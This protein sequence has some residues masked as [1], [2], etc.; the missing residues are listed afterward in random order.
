M[1]I[2]HSKHIM[3][4]AYRAALVPSAVSIEISASLCGSS[5]SKFKEFRLKQSPQLQDM[6]IYICTQ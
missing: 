5:H 2:V 6:A 3:V 1:V 4:Q